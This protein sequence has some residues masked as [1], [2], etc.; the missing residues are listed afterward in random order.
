[1]RKRLMKRKQDRIETS[2]GA[3]EKFYRPLIFFEDSE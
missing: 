1:M 3:V 2:Q